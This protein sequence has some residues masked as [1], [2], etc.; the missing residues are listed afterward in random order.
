M[1]NKFIKS[2]VMLMS[3]SLFVAQADAM[4]KPEGTHVPTKSYRVTEKDGFVITEAGPGRMSSKN[5]SKRIR[6]DSVNTENI[7]YDAFIGILDGEENKIYADIHL[8][9]DFDKERLKRTLN[10]TQEYLTKNR[11]PYLCLSHQHAFDGTFTDFDMLG[12]FLSAFYAQ[13]IIPDSII[14]S[15]VGHIG[16]TDFGQ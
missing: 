16:N 14:D 12:Q 10:I 13:G 7:L 3:V 5:Y 9:K 6:I 8:N 2:S 4:E 15:I 11:V 1:I